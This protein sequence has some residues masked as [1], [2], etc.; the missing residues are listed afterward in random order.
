M[1]YEVPSD[2]RRDRKTRIDIDRNRNLAKFSPTYS[3][4]TSE[5]SIGSPTGGAAATGPRLGSLVMNPELH[6][7]SIEISWTAGTGDLKIG[8]LVDTTATA[9]QGKFLHLTSGTST[10]GRGVFEPQNTTVFTDVPQ[11]LSVSGGWS[12]T[13][14]TGT[15]DN[16]RI[17][18]QS[19]SAIV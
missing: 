19:A 16:D 15:D 10:A 18:M 9:W 13:Y 7:V 17:V 8:D 3:T 6:T 1:S 5:A 2:E 11:T 12:A 4:Q 14:T